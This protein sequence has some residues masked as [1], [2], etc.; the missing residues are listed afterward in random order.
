MSIQREIERIANNVQDTLSTI[1]QT[2][3]SVPQGAN[4]DNLPALAAAL[5]NTKQD[6]LTGAAGQIVG[7]DSSGNAAAQDAPASGMT[8]AQ[9]DRRYLQ[10]TGGTV[11]GDV[12]IDQMTITQQS[13]IT[14]SEAD[15]IQSARE[16]VLWSP[17][18]SINGLY[19]S[20]VASVTVGNG[21]VLLL[22]GKET[23]HD[24]FGKIRPPVSHLV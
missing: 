7:F 6:K 13:D 1:A 20:E 10:L 14:G 4:S 24:E 22:A 19:G 23:G 15:T 18:V 17:Y 21:M 11:T 5:A 8:Q 12:H 9:A 3:V 2:G 16:L